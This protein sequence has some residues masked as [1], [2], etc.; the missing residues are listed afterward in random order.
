MLVIYFRKY[1]DD[2]IYL[3]SYFMEVLGVFCGLSWLKYDF[4]YVLFI[5]VMMI[6]YVILFFLVIFFLRFVKSYVD[7]LIVLEVNMK[8]WFME[9]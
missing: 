7:F 3:F 9:K 6:E 4:N 1:V 8:N 5:M 2:K